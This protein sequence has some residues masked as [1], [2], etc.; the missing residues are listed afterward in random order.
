MKDQYRKRFQTREAAT[1]ADAESF[2]ASV[3]ASKL[4]GGEKGGGERRDFNSSAACVGEQDKHG[5][6]DAVAAASVAAAEMTGI[7]AKTNNTPST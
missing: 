6:K 2:T 3:S 7:E 1:Q 4:S 5:K